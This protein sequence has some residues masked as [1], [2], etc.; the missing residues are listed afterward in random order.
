M[1]Q[2]KGR[3]AQQVVCYKAGYKPEDI[4]I[5]TQ[6]I[7]WEKLFKIKWKEKNKT[8]KT[9]QN[10]SELWS[11]FT[12]THTD[13]TKVFKESTDKPWN[14]FKTVNYKLKYPGQ[15]GLHVSQKNKQKKWIN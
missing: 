1:D 3:A 14:I 8:L 7:Y 10:I 13:K 4:L 9:E 6:K 11:N 5:E 12:Y 2:K 15:P